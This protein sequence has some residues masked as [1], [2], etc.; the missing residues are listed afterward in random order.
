MRTLEICDEDG[1]LLRSANLSDGEKKG[2]TASGT[3]AS[4]TT[5]MKASTTA[6]GTT[7]SGT[8][9]TNGKSAPY[10]I[11]GRND[12]TK[13]IAFGITRADAEKLSAFVTRKSDALTE[14]HGYLKKKTK[15]WYLIPDASVA[16]DR[17]LYT[18]LSERKRLA[19][20]NP[21]GGSLS[22]RPP[23]A[24]PIPFLEATRDD[25]E[26]L[27]ES[28]ASTKEGYPKKAMAESFAIDAKNV[29]VV[30]SS[31][32]LTMK[33]YSC[34]E[35]ARKGLDEK[36]GK[37]LDEFL[38]QCKVLGASHVALLAHVSADTLKSSDSSRTR[39][40]ELVPGPSAGSF[41][42]VYSL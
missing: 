39:L 13:V 16:G 41:F 18:K 36:E 29:I 24:I 33:M 22:K 26:R 8:K 6:S 17:H 1:N 42:A 10:S 40:E 30:V 19:F 31:F 25:V 5:G 37:L 23:S 34:N 27:L 32:P 11:T 9:S 35:G 38:D 4:G 28:K 2:A 21:D 3:T 15:V 20:C 14:M 7:A 12:E